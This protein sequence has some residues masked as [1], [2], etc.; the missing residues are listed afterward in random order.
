MVEKFTRKKGRI[1][2]SVF[3]THEIVYKKKEKS[4]FNSR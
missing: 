3:Y 1:F 4:K 2:T